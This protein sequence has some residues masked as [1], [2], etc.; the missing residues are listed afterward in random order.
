MTGQTSGT[1]P[2][3][4]GGILLK[5]VWTPDEGDIAVQQAVVRGSIRDCDGTRFPS[6]FNRLDNKK[7]LPWI[8]SNVFGKFHHKLQ[9]RIF[10]II[11]LFKA[12]IQTFALRV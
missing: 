4:S 11:S 2:G 5:Q 12:E 10:F 1:C 3:D 9:I 6:I 8:K 7:V